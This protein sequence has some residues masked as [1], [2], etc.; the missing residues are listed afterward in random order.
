MI[1]ITEIT[2]GALN[3]SNNDNYNNVDTKVLL[4]NIFVDMLG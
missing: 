4:V 1:T 3:N 2:K